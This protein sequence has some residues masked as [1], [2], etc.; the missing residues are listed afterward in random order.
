VATDEPL[1]SLQL[2]ATSLADEMGFVA[3]SDL[4]QIMRAQPSDSYRIIGGHMMTALS[5]RWRLGADL[6]RETGDADIGVPPVTIRER[7][8]VSDLLGLG[9]VQVDGSRFERELPQLR[10]ALTGAAT[11]NLRA[12]IDV[13]VPAYD[14]R[15]RA[16]KR[17]GDVVASQALGLALALQLPPVTMALRLARLDHSHIDA[18]LMFSN[19]VAALAMKALV[20]TVRHKDTDIVDLWRCLEICQA[21]HLRL[22]DFGTH[23]DLIRAA[24]ITRDLFADR[25][26]VGMRSLSAYF[27]LSPT[28]AD[29]R[30][31]RIKALLVSVL[32]GA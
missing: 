19:E 10:P 25:N 21:A 16:N 23:D 1:T 20:T 28:G 4:S 12:A 13:L 2:E 30:H 15:P 3:L 5:H 29:Q 18:D 27:G 32:G 9:Y 14:S 11:V 17:V 6:Y 31:T 7:D 8:L 22:A 24:H 26:G